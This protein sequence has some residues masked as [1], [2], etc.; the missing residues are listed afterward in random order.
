MLCRTLYFFLTTMI[1][2]SCASSEKVLRRN[3]EKELAG[4]SGTYA[5]AFKDLATGE[6]LLIREREVFHAASTMK[7]P[8]MIE[9][10]KQ[11]NEGRISLND[12]I[13]VKN[14]FKSI[15]DGSHYS[16]SPADDSDH[17]LY[18]QVG[19]K[20]TVYSLL[21]DMIVVTSNLATN[22]IIEL[23]DARQVMKTMNSLGAKDIQVLRGVEDNMAFERGMNN[24]TNAYDQM[25]IYS[26]IAR[27]EV[28]NREASKSM[29]DIL[30][31][32]KYNSIIPARLP[33]VVKVAHKTGWTSSVEHDAGI[34]MLPGGRRY[35]LVLLSKDF[36]DKQV[37][38]RTM[39]K[40]SE[41]IYMHV[42]SKGG[43]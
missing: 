4:V 18:A 17:D 40:I 10:F 28:V 34:V 35:V 16:L 22:I 32:Q 38:I 15:A 43:S 21:Y 5:V 20:K 26:A 2:A 7:T 1:L 36:T 39:A 19:N 3:I 14:D 11:A 31:D 41:M 13:T 8:V 42:V 6:E 29:I 27:G 30:L 37:A 24:T 23:V 33:G 12:S 9:V 25:L